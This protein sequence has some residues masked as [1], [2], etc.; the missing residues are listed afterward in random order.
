MDNLNES[1]LFDSNID[2][3]ANNELNSIG[4]WAK[5]IAIVSMIVILLAIFSMLFLGFAFSSFGSY[6]PAEFR[7]AFNF[8]SS[9]LIVSVIFIIVFVL[10]GLY[11]F[12]LYK[13]GNNLIKATTYQDQDALE[14]AFGSYKTYLV[15]TGVL[16]ILGLIFSFLGLLN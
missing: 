4:T 15:I 2:N 16:G 3:I 8:D 6:M 5:R 9:G 12:L 14:T 11:V 1:S 13:F 10:V 7:R